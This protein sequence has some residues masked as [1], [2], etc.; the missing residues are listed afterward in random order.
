VLAALPAAAVDLRGTAASGS[1]TITGLTAGA[2]GNLWFTQITGSSYLA[3]STVAG[4]ITEHSPALSGSP[5]GLTTGPEGDLWLTE[6]GAGKIARLT[7]SGT[8]TE[9]TAASGSAPAMITAGPDGN[10]WFTESGGEGAIGRITPAG[11]ITNFKAG[12]TAGSQPLGIT[13]GPDGNLW[14]T[15]AANPGRIGRITTSGVITEFAS[16]LTADSQPLGITAGPDGNLWF[17]EAANPGR[18]GRITTSG[19]ITEFSQGL[20]PNVEPRAITTG[21][22]GNLY[23]TEPNGAGSIG[24][25]TTGGVITQWATP[26]SGSLPEDIVTGPDGNLWFTEHHGVHK[27]AMMTV[28]PAIGSSK[29][30]AVSTRTASLE[31]NVGANSQETN[32]SFEYGTTSAYGSRTSSSSAGSGAGRSTVSS[33]V[34]GLTPATLYHFRVVATNPTGTSYGLD[35]TFTTGSIQGAEEGTI[36]PIVPSGLGAGPLG[37]NPNTVLPPRLGKT[38]IARPVS[39]TVLVR[40]PSTAPARRL[41]AGEDIPVGALVDASNGRLLVTTALPSPGNTQSAAVWGGAFV[42]GQSASGQGM[43]T[44]ALATGRPADCPGLA[45]RSSGHAAAAHARSSKTHS[46]WATDHGGRFSTRG[47]NSVAT[48][49]GT[50]WGTIERCDGTMTVVRRGLVSVRSLRTGQTVLVRAGHSHL[51]KN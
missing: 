26:T 42:I 17:T 30:S 21:D 47:Q 49:R 11:V 37:A 35:E 10:L 19:V 23:F 12:L 14:F 18:I 4:Q 5:L 27:I 28:A 3:S 1:P 15:E 9:F 2:D 29:A 48:V 25:I 32:Y 6:A 13:A 46:L 51:M 7:T 43:T 16:G 41:L 36:A 39:G 34:G 20:T 33:F 38:A 8:V 22:D 31:A 45:R 44:F 50:Y 40:I 24:E